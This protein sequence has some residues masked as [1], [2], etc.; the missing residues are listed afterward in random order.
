MVPR[1]QCAPRV[2]SM[3]SP[4]ALSR[5][6]SHLRP[7]WKEPS[8]RRDLPLSKLPPRRA[9][10]HCAREPGGGADF[11]RAR[12]SALAGDRPRSLEALALEPH[13]QRATP[14][15]RKGR[16]RRRTRVGVVFP[17]TNYDVA[18]YGRTFGGGSSCPATEAQ[19]AQDS[20]AGQVSRLCV[21]AQ[22]R[23]AADRRSRQG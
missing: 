7:D 13:S 11:G 10:H 8:L 19:D 6:P 21:P 20:R 12:L 17:G 18:R 16:R 14:Q 2:D 15:H 3:R 5:R 1:I 23:D 4:V 22:P 9:N